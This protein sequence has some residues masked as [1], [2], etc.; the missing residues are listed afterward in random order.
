MNV[1]VTGIGVASA[2]GLNV[3]ENLLSLESGITGIERSTDKGIMLG[4]VKLSN[5]EIINKYNLPK[6]DYSRT[7]LL[8][9][10]TAKEAWGT[11]M[12]NQDIQTGLVSATSVGG[13]DR[14]EQY[15]FESQKDETLDN[16]HLMTYDNG[17]TTERLAKAL[18]IKGF[19]G[20]ISTACSSGAN[21]IM[22]GAR[23]IQAGKLDRVLVGASDPIAGFNI[24]GFSSL[25]IYDQD[26]CR[27]FDDSRNGLNLG[28]GAGF[29]VLENEKSISKTTNTPLCLLSG[30]NNSTDA[31]HQT[32][33]SE[34]GKGATLSMNLALNKAQ[35]SKE[36]IS[37]INTHGTGTKNNDLSE[38]R[39]LLNVF[40]DNM[41]PFSSTKGFT[42]HTLAASGAI[43]A[44]YSVLSILSDATLPSLNFSSPISE[45]GLIPETVFKKNVNI[46]HVLTNSF[47]FGG[48]CSSLI[49]SKIQ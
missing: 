8:A 24:N 10:H 13:L 14:M 5:D 27:P 46:E 17:R 11:N 31:F 42:G 33:S 29:L 28:E 35:I 38:S 7:P 25:M 6:E 21:A 41:P 44:V 47:G 45:T 1:F 9:I 26:L 40:G 15:Y 36:K 34:D 39:A 49:F 4:R 22:Y 3:K 19:I 16:Y 30:W 18:G 48:N 37:Y 32:A 12:P 43:E 20:T 2:I 23:L